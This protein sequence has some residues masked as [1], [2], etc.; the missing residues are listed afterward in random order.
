MKTFT[1]G[2]NN[3]EFFDQFVHRDFVEQE[4][5]FSKIYSYIEKYMSLKEDNNEE[6]Q[7]LNDKVTDNKTIWIM[8]MQGIEH[9]PELVKKCYDSVCRNK[10]DGY[11][12]ILLSMKNIS[13]YIILSKAVQEKYEK[14]NITA[15]HLSDILRL[16]L[17]NMY[18]GCWID[19][20]VYCSGPIL[21][22]MVSDMFLFKLGSILSDPVIKMSSWWIAA[23]K[24]N[25][26][27]HESR[28]ALQMYW[29][30]EEQ[31]CD[32]FLL[33]II[34]SRVIDTDCS[35]K[36]IFRNIPFFN[37]RNAQI[38]V[39]NLGAQYCKRDWNIMKDSSH[40]Q[41]LTYKNRYIKGDIY[42]FYTALL[43]GE[44]DRI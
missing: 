34:M 37:S 43:D 25:R 8:W 1:T 32:Y 3:M 33:H 4:Y 40:I 41:K 27:I 29:E 38:L 44:L 17:L 35:C 28:H 19:A 21:D 2:E 9:A 36:E 42:N 11:E 39:E 23:D 18:G 12:I 5:K 7:K 31:L 16:E 24:G 30:N 15:T 13:E 26:I 22:Y 14:G 20:T 6:C 10:P